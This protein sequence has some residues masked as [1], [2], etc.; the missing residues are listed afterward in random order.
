MTMQKQDLIEFWD[1]EYYTKV[2]KVK[3]IS[4]LKT[5]EKDH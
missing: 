3:I 5:L 4:S 2:F 1:Y